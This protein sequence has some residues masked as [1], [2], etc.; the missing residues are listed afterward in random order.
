M[1]VVALYKMAEPRT[2]VPM[3]GSVYFEENYSPLCLTG[4]SGTQAGCLAELTNTSIMIRYGVLLMAA[5]DSQGPAGKSVCV[6]SCP[7]YTRDPR[8]MNTI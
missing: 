7:E 2:R 8:F 1:V 5:R 6:H 4:G 3:R